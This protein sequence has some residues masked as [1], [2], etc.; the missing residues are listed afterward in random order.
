LGFATAQVDTGESRTG[1][2]AVVVL[3]IL[4]F[5]NLVLFAVCAVRSPRAKGTPVDDLV[6]QAKLAPV[7]PPPSSRP[8]VV[9]SDNILL[10]PSADELARRRAR[11]AH[12][13]AGSPSMGMWHH[14]SLG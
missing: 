2:V 6:R 7:P 5:C 11:A 4:L 8:R 10:F 9:G 3:D 13:S 14:P 1:E 12:P